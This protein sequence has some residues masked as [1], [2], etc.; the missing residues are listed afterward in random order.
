VYCIDT[1][2]DEN[3]MSS[4]KSLLHLAQ[5]YTQK[6]LLYPQL[7]YGFIKSLNN[8]AAYSWRSLL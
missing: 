8:V 6:P 4:G 1:P 7:T 5:G 2:P 3:G